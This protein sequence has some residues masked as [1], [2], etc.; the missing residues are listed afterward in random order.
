M[1]APVYFQ[2]AHVEGTDGRPANPIPM[3][4]ELRTEFIDAF[5]RSKEWHQTSWM[6][7]WTAKPPTDLMAYQELVARVRP[8]WII[9]TGTGGGGR[10]FFL[11][12]ICDLLDHGRVLAI[13]DYPVPKRAEHP[14]IEH[15]A[16][17]PAD[18]ETAAAVNELV[19]ENRRALLILGA[20]KMRHLMAMYE[21]FGDLVP[22]GS[23]VVFEDT[24]LNGHPVW[25]GF[26]PGPWEAAKRLLDSGDFERDVTMEGRAH[27]QHRRVPEALEGDGVVKIFGIGLNKTG[28]SSLHRALEL[29]GYSSLH[30]GGLD[31]H[32]RISRA[33]DEGEPMLRYIDPEPDAIVDVLAITYYFHLA[34]VQ[35]PGS[36]FILTLRDIDEWVD[37]RRRH[38]ERNQQMKEA[39]KYDGPFLTVDPDTW[40]AEYVR[41]EAVV[42]A[43]FANRPG[44]P[45]RLPAGRRG[46]GAALQ[47]SR[48]SR[49]GYAVPLGEPRPPRGHDMN[50]DWAFADMTVSNDLLA[51]RDALRARLEDEGYL[52]FKE[53]IDRDRVLALRRDIPRGPGR[54]GLDRRRRQAR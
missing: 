24:I 26:G 34:D 23:Y 35:Y 50:N 33:I 39:G 41:H 28:T 11:A 42:R 40:T 8:D 46:L 16:R 4:E 52:Y 48:P 14:R 9:E 51:D 38:V 13:D 25:T 12:S 19:G 29:L 10:A 7:T 15:L 1:G 45:A 37:S 44:G 53:L 47:V 21:N 30:G 2:L 17:D 49:P 54:P 20:S 5:W 43:Y 3:P 6:G 36:R 31:A 27:V 18:P 22:V 32:E